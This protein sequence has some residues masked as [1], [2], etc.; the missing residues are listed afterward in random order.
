MDLIFYFG[1]E[2][3]R[4]LPQFLERLGYAVKGLGSSSPVLEAIQGQNA[5]LIVIDGRINS[6]LVD[7]CTFFRGQESTREVP[8][9]C[10]TPEHQRTLDVFEAFE[11]VEVV[12]S[13]L[14]VGALASRIAT[15]L[16][17]R[18]AAGLSNERSS[19]A[20]INAALRDHNTRFQKD[21]EE[22]RAI[23]QGLLPKQLPSDPRFQI[24]VS[25]QPLEQVGG[26]WYFVDFPDRKHLRLHIADVSGHGLP[27][28]FIGSMAKLAMVAAERD[29]PDELL[30][31]MNK[32][33]APQLPS[34]RFMTMGTCL[35][36]PATGRVQ[37]ARAGHGPALILKRASNEVTQLLG[38]GFPLGFVAEASYELIEHTLE[39]GDALLLYTDG[40]TEAQNRDMKQFGVE[41]LSAALTAAP[42][43]GGSG[44]V[45][46]FIVDAFTT[47]LEGRLLKDDV[48][49]MLLR[50]EE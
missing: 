39:P 18:K 49:L 25:Y 48:T 12:P 33:L 11:R 24:A 22:A 44:E 50:R 1:D 5:D 20:E 29:R 13:P 21:L 40:V 10:I 4:Q 23:Q 28:A 16:R 27:A 26:D 2:R 42:S 6:E 17:L 36:D 30:A 8:I 35:Y 3:E 31:V 38:N 9:V 15:Q 46:R 47:F 37:W 43:K 7:L 34:G 19:L 14:S 41:R 32:F 45:L